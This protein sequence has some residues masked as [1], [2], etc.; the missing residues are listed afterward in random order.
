[1]RLSL[2]DDMQYT[3]KLDYTC[4]WLLYSCDLDIHRENSEHPELNTSVT[5]SAPPDGPGRSGIL[6]GSV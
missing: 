5:K 1:M 4:Q 6:L 3:Y 2:M